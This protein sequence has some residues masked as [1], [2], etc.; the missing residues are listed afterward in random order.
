MRPELPHTPTGSAQP[1]PWVDPASLPNYGDISGITGSAPDYV[2]QLNLNT[3]ISYGV[4]NKDTFG[5]KAGKAVKFVDI[6][7]DRKHTRKGRLEA[8]T[9]AE[10]VVTQ[11]ARD[12]EN[13]N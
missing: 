2:K 12:F 13:S 10:L 4:G 9:V 6:S 3:Y 5:Y 11:G 8:T 1:G 7:I